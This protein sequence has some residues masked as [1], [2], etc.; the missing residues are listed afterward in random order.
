VPESSAIDIALLARLNGDAELV[1]LLPDRFWFDESP[2]NGTRFGMITL[3]DAVDEHQ[4]GGRSYE[5]RLYQV[6]TIVRTTVANAGTVSVEATERI[7]VLLEQNV[8]EAAGY[9]PMACFREE[10]IQYQETDVVDP[11]IRFLHRGARYRVV[12]S[13]NP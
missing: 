10:P 6:Q 5:A 4:F 9:S 12:M 8:L 2:K 11:A 13:V 7:D 1:A 3:T